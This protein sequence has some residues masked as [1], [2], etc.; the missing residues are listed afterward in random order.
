MSDQDSPRRLSNADVLYEDNHLLVINKPTGV[1]TMGAIEG[2]PTIHAMAA[3]YLKEK[4]NKPGNVF[5]GIVSRLDAMTSGALVLAR[6]SK[7]ASRLS[8]QFAGSTGE[9]STSARRKKQKASRPAEKLYLAVLEGNLDDTS[10]RGASHTLEHVVR[11]DDRAHRMR[12]CQP[13]HPDG[14]KATLRFATL[15]NTANRTLVAVRLLTGRKHQ[16]RVQFAEYGHPVWGDTKYG[17]QA[18]FSAGLALHCWQ[19]LITHPTRDE[20]LRFV[21]DPP[22]SWKPFQN[23]IL[24]PN[25]RQTIS[26]AL[27]W[28]FDVPTPPKS[29]PIP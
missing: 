18:S 3:A 15:S 6:T 28:S 10:G 5:V 4:Y 13:S 26:Q 24:A 8:L 20:R 7:A 25:T 23:E 29:P 11:K 16:I 2:R 22:P 14:Q 17:A 27:N 1:A 9:P 19:L 12:V 21:A